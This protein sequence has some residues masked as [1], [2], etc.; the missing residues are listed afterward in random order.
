VVTLDFGSL[1]PSVMCELNVCASTRLTRAEARFG[2]YSFTQPP[3]PDLTGIWYRGVDK[4]A[5]IHETAD[6][7]ISVYSFA[8]KTTVVARYSDQ[9]N[10]SITLPG[11][12]VW[13]LEDGGYAMR[14]SANE[15]WHRADKDV[16]VMVDASVREGVIPALERTLKLDRKAAKKRLAQ[17]EATSD[18]A[19]A[20]FFENLQ[21]GIKVLMNALYGG[22][23][24]GKGGIFPESSPLASAITARGRS[25]IVMVKKTLEQRFWLLEGTV[26]GFEGEPPPVRAQ[27]LR[28][29]YGDTDSVMIHFPGCSLQQ[30]AHHGQRLST[31]FDTQMLKAPHTLAFEKI[32]FPT[33]FYKV[34]SYRVRVRVL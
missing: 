25:L 13:Q 11:G 10:E 28:V 22:L 2:G 7:A 27:P 9:L 19:A 18:K 23:G 8:D 21:S 15:V 31:F 32:L 34:R 5:R 3:A 26:G 1:Y 14:V 12:T 16:L 24:T 6:D 20:S 30:T 4:V 17:A 33:A 29:L